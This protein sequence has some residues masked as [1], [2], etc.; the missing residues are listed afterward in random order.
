M[1]NFTLDKNKKVHF[2]GIGGINMSS[3]ADILLYRGFSVSGSDARTSDLINKLKEKGAEISIGQRASN[4]KGDEGCVVYTAAISDDNP[5]LMMARELGIPCITRADF[6]GHLMLEFKDVIC[7]SGTHGKTTTTS[8]ISQIFLDAGK[9]P[10]I[11][12][13]GILRSINSNTRIGSQDVMVAEACEYKNSFLSFFPTVGLILNIKEDHMDFFKDIDD[14]R[15]SFKKFAE[16]IPE[17]GALVIGE[18]I[19]DLSF[20]TEG[21]KCSILTFAP[22]SSSADV[23]AKNI[24]FN[25]Y[26]CAG[27]DLYYKGELLGRARLSITGMHGVYDALAASAAALFMGISPQQI[28]GSLGRFAGVKRRFEKKGVLGGV[29]IIDDYAHHPDEINATLSSALAYP[30]KKLWVVFQPHTYSRTVRFLDEFA[31]ALSHADAV[32]LT[33]IYAAREVNTY[34]VSSKDICDRLTALG[35]ECFYL[36][37]FDET[38]TFLLQNCSDGDVLITM[39]AGDVVSIAD[40]LLGI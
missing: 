2:I 7:V 30:H 3:L 39:G 21:L 19:D 9:D 25:E 29:T 13:G 16:L 32:I 36:P 37:T 12:A 15:A 28:I 11:M 31:A 4:I 35:T 17:N 33:D 6:F 8:I 24:T 22:E 23:T 40:N 5:E 26:A 38:E 10:T 1:T 27:F 20:F 14:I 34:G 18:G